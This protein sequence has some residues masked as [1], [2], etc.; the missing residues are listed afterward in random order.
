MTLGKP[1]RRSAAPEPL[2]SASGPDQHHPRA[3]LEGIE[4]TGSTCESHAA[5]F[6]FTP[7]YRPAAGVA[8]FVCGTPSPIALAA[9]ECGVDTVLAA[10]A[11]G[12]MAAVRAKSLALTE[13]FIQLVGERCAGQ[14]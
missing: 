10:E 3:G 2:S 11:L 12:G 5:P 6:A 7:G 1:N 14:Q 9:L 8:R 4:R 13:L